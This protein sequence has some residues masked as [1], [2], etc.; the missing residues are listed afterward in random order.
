MCFLSIAPPSRVVQGGRVHSLGAP[1]RAGAVTWPANPPHTRQVHLSAHRVVHLYFM[2]PRASVF[3][4]TAGSLWMAQ[5]GFIQVKSTNPSSPA[6][7]GVA[8]GAG[9]LGPAWRSCGCCCS[10]S[11]SPPS[12]QRSACSLAA[13]LQPAACNPAQPVLVGFS[14][15]SPSQLFLLSSA[16]SQLRSPC[17]SALCSTSHSCMMDRL[18]W[19]TQQGVCLFAW[20]HG[21]ALVHTTS[22]LFYSK[23][24]LLV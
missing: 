7:A 17:T 11:V 16:P 4:A 18:M 21:K 12:I 14:C 2:F 20:H 15:S 24:Q 10:A 13:F 19:R 8:L 5:Q 23:P 6:V 1:S 3:Q 9:G 22:V